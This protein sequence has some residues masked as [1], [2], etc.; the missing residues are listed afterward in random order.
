L[1]TVTAIAVFV[2]VLE[3][4]YLERRKQFG[5][6]FHQFQIGGTLVAHA[7]AFLNAHEVLAC[8]ALHHDVA[9]ASMLKQLPGSGRVGWFH[10]NSFNAEL[11][12]AF[13]VDICSSVGLGSANKRL[14]KASSSAVLTLSNRG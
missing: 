14:I 3:Q 4:H 10:A 13:A 9:A 1:E 2:R 7:V 12:A 5:S 8:L 11:T 6:C